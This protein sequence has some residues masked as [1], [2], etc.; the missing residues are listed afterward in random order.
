ME[1]VLD[2]IDN[3]TYSTCPIQ[4]AQTGSHNIET[5]CAR[6]RSDRVRDID[7]LLKQL[8][9]LHAKL[10]SCTQIASSFSE[11][12]NGHTLQQLARDTREESEQMTQLT[13]RAQRDG[14]A[15][16]ALTVITLIYLPTTVVL[17]SL[18]S[19]HP[20]SVTNKSRRTS[21]QLL[22]LTRIMVR[23]SWLENGGSFLSSARR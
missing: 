15:V 8:R 21:S 7:M 16:K 11:L 3:K 20:R 22:S 2:V 19:S 10:T 4:P 9:S 17:V 23:W 14:A 6:F 18:L 13:R 5:A 1:I 12:S